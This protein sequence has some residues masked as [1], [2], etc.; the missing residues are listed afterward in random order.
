MQDDF[1]YCAEL[2]R[3]ADRDRFL[4]TLFAPAERRDALYALYAFN[5]EATRV[6]EVAREAL[7]GEIRLQWWIDVIN[8]ER[9]GEARANPVAAALLEVIE[10]HK[11][12][13]VKLVALI[14]AHRFDLYEESMADVAD[15][16]NYAMD[17][18]SA[19]IASATQIL[20]AAET[21][22]VAKPAGIASAI[23]GLLRALPIHAARHQLYL[24]RGLLARYDVK[25]EDL[26]AGRS[27][28]GLN[29]ALAE[30]RNLAR[31][32]LSEARERL[33]ELP[34]QA[35]PALLPVALVRPS[36]DRL[37]HCDAFSPVELS[38]WRRQWLIWRAARNPARI[39]R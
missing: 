14:D 18:S 8:G 25:S 35:L 15:L 10:R 3:T 30:L 11:L 17:T 27:S 1:A 20:A 33:N 28:V 16:E 5:V 39:A 2:V 23:V 26:F 29:A 36:L 34:R 19:L 32:R 6:R 4:A 38:P 37:E 7:P 12:A 31:R 9:A 21:E 22:A 13:A 24:P